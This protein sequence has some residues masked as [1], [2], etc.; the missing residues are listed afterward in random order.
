MISGPEAPF[1]GRKE[2]VTYSCISNSIEGHIPISLGSLLTVEL[3]N[4][5]PV[6]S[7]LLIV[8]LWIS[9]VLTFYDRLIKAVSVLKGEGIFWIASLA[10]LVHYKDLLQRVLNDN[11]LLVFGDKGKEEERF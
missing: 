1:F 2:V 11:F 3:I 7:S 10:H 6:R 9:V 5:R 4:T 8:D